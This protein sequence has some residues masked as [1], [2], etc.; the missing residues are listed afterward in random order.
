MRGRWEF[1][2]A[3][4]L[5]AAAQAAHEADR[6]IQVD[7]SAW[8]IRNVTSPLTSSADLLAEERA[9][10]KAFPQDAVSLAACRR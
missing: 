6:G 7:V 8:P 1:A 4:L 10:L 5:A 9:I 2:V 3:I